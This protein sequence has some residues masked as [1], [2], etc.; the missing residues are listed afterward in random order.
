MPDEIRQEE[1]CTIGFWF[2]TPAPS[3]F[4]DH[5]I[6]PLTTAPFVL[7]ALT[8]DLALG[9]DVQTRVRLTGAVAWQ[10]ITNAAFPA[11][12][13]VIFRIYRNTPVTGPLVFS[14]RD[15]SNAVDGACRKAIFDATDIPPVFDG[16]TLVSYFLTAELPLIGS[17]ANVT[18][19]ISFASTKLATKRAD[20]ATGEPV[21]EGDC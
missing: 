20:L 11:E 4:T 14:T 7:A 19:A 9:V 15:R 13:D 1:V 18:G 17:A 12:V 3:S 2:G 21:G 16:Y 5:L 6:I 10:A 8:G